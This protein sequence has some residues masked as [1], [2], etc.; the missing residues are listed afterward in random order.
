M[1]YT[2]IAAAQDWFFRHQGLKLTDPPVIYHVAVWASYDKEDE[3]G[4]VRSE[5]VGLIA[6]DFNTLESS[7][8]LHSPPPVKGCYLHLSQLKD[9]ELEQIKKR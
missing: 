8:R 9:E 3:N 2:S 5:V 1:K 7:G 4:N 6:P